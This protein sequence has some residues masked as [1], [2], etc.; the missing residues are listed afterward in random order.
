MDK[1]ARVDGLIDESDWL[2]F[3]MLNVDVERYP[4]SDVV[5]RFLR[6]RGDQ[7]V[8]KQVVV[9]GLNA[10][11][12]LD[13]TEISQLTTYL[14]VYGKTQPF[15][16]N[17]V[18]ALFRAFTPEGAPPVDVPGTR[19]ATLTERLSADANRPIE[20]NLSLDDQPVASN[21]GVEG[22]A[23]AIP[24]HAGD[25]VRTRVGPV[26]D[27]NGH[28][29]PDG[30]VVTFLASYEGEATALN[31]EPALTRDGVAQRDI[32]LERG[33][34][35]RVSAQVHSASTGEP[36]S[37][38]VLDSGVAPVANDAGLAGA[39]SA[40]PAESMAT[41]T[42]AAAPL[43]PLHR[44]NIVTLIV[45]LL[46]MAATL[47]LLLS[48]QI[49]IMPRRLLVHSMLWALIFGLSGY[50]LYGLGLFPGGGWLYDSLRIWGAAV[51]VFVSMIFPLLWLQL[52]PD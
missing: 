17:A 50:I 8:G 23:P 1:Q 11:Y 16:E 10:P 48:V 19:F 47:G 3:A 45:S 30:T 51:A 15:L 4:N 24:V 43:E 42:D 12:F 2:I 27:R 7:L 32:F 13:A 40:N 33:G 37:V 34:V 41:A 25:A 20:I 28:R 5:K 39:S 21:T 52:R 38:A 46:T 49:R 26:Y 36:V 29:V 14:G 6:Q 22:D 9:L 18:R 35:L 31:V 44:V